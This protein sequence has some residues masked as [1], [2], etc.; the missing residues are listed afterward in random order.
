[1]HFEVL[2]ESDQVQSALPACCATHLTRL[3]VPGW[4][5]ERYAMCFL[6]PSQPAPNITLSKYAPYPFLYPRGKTPLIFTILQLL[7]L[8]CF[9]N[10]CATLSALLQTQGTWRQVRRRRNQ[11]KPMRLSRKPQGAR[12]IN[13]HQ[14]MKPILHNIA[15]HIQITGRINEFH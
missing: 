11:G 9:Y 8:S 1:M 3:Q 13:K 4:L 12:C 6:E 15:D 7:H 10:L 2:A 14:T 5:A